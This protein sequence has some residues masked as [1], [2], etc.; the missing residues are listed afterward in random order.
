M[1]EAHDHRSVFLKV[2]DLG[3]T[4]SWRKQFDHLGSIHLG[5]AFDVALR[6]D[7]RLHFVHQAHQRIHVFGSIDHDEAG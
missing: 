4:G 7:S 2:L 3:A 6:C 5:G 1:P